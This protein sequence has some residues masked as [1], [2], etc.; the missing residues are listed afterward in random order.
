MQDCGPNRTALRSKV[1]KKPRSWKRLDITSHMHA[2]ICVL[3]NR[4]MHWHVFRWIDRGEDKVRGRSPSTSFSLHCFFFHR[5]PLRPPKLLILI[6][7]PVS[8]YHTASTHYPPSLS[9]SLGVA[10]MAEAVGLA[11]SIA[12]LVGVA[13]KVFG[14][15]HEYFGEAMNAQEDIKQLVSE[16]SSLASYL[17][18]FQRLL[19]PAKFCKRRIQIRSRNWCK[20]ARIF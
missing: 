16:I 6:R 18:R 17:S 12:G 9:I 13:L 10:S 1:A 15:C 8:L 7:R 4:R 14:L 11:A 5:P 2:R 19:R 3:Y 20:N